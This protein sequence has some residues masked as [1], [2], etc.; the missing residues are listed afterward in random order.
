MKAILIQGA[1]NV[2]KLVERLSRIVQPQPPVVFFS[3]FLG[4]GG[5]AGN[6]DVMNQR[7]SI[8]NLDPPLPEYVIFS[9]EVASNKESL[10]IVVKVNP[11]YSVVV[12][13]LCLLGI[14]LS[15]SALV[16]RHS[17][18]LDFPWIVDGSGFLF[19][20]VVFS[21]NWMNARVS[22]RLFRTKVLRII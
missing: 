7:F 20:L 6:V 22:Y 8:V 5:I 12:R 19:A 13:I 2:H 15:I 1:D 11:M 14:V 3:G 16:F 21:V 10:T 18:K 17:Y 4:K 9:G